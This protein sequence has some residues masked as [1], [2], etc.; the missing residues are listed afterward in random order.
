MIRIYITKTTICID[1]LNFTAAI[2]LHEKIKLSEIYNAKEKPR[3]ISKDE[4][5]TKK[6]L[7]RIKL[8]E[9]V[10][11]NHIFIA[12]FKS[13]RLYLDEAIIQKPSVVSEKN[14]VRK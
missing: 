2:E 8:Q 14:T 13:H 12:D 10:K 3:F 1:I 6:M 4:L 9:K 11:S 5:L 7:K